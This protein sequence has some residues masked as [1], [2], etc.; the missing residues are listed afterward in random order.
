MV[1]HHRFSR[2]V[3]TGVAL[4]LSSLLACATTNGPRPD[5][6]QVPGVIIDYSPASSGCYIGSPSI[7]I[8][9]NG[10]YV[11]S[12]DFFGPEAQHTTSPKT[13]V[14]SSK[15]QGKT[16]KKIAEINPC[17]WGK[18]FVHN[19]KLYLLGT[20]NEYGDVL[21]RRSDDGGKTWSNPQGPT[22]GLLREGR[23]HCA[24][25]PVLVHNGRIWRSMEGFTG[26][27]WGAFETMVISAPVDA[28]LLLA[29]SWTFSERL[30]KPDEFVWLEGN[31]VLDADKKIVNVLRTNNVGK[32]KAA[33]VHVSDDGQELS[34]DLSKDWIDMPGG[35]VKFTIYWD[36]KVSRYW[37][38]VSKQTN[39][40]AERNNLVLISSTDL[41]NWKVESPLFFH[42]DDK[43]HAWQYVDWLFEDENIIFVSRTAYED[44]LG[45]APR[46]HDANYLTFHRIKGFRSRAPEPLGKGR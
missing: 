20:R 31:V 5:H 39:P 36:E 3:S 18:L 26:G 10:N 12:H 2:L 16:W 13:A 46:G 22:T 4:Y 40:E 15:N 19:D 24:P 33:I 43:K 7:A 14:F 44:G 23:Y 42:A 29:D 38:I 1:T 27:K 34:F 8:F 17:F 25:C 21:I 37:S 32:D 9:P 35:G 41:R 28:D 30:P 45:G 11:A 6:S